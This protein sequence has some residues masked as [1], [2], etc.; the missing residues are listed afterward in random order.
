[1]EGINF[2][3]GLL[4]NLDSLADAFYDNIS[5]DRR[6]ETI[7]NA[8]RLYALKLAYMYYHWKGMRRHVETEGHEMSEAVDYV[9]KAFWTTSEQPMVKKNFFV[10]YNTYLDD[11]FTLKPQITHN[12][13]SAD[14]CYL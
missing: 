5:K 7:A 4:Y 6:K 1:M 8:S 10:L 11:N 2:S 3:V 9:I 12:E 13:Q 14:S